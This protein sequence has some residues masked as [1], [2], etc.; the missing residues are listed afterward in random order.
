[1]NAKFKKND[2]VKYSEESKKIFRRL[3]SEDI[4]FEAKGIIKGMLAACDD[5]RNRYRVEMEDGDLRYI[6]EEHLEIG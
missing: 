6:A 5:N 3:G 2:L 1:M 4:Y